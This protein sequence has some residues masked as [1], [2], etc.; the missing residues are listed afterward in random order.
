MDN[1]TLTVKNCHRAKTVRLKEFPQNGNWE[2]GFRS[3][4]Q[5]RG[6]FSTPSN[7]AKQGDAT[8]IVADCELSNYEVI[9]WKYEE[10]FEDLFVLAVR[11]FT[12]TSHTPEVRA[13]QYIR[14]Y[15]S[16]LQSDLAQLPKESHFDYIAKFKMRIEDLFRLHSRCL[17]SM[18]IGLAR[19]PTKRAQS[20]SNSYDK[21]VQ[22]FTKWRES[23]LKRAERAKE[24]AKSPEEKLNDEWKPLKKD[25][26]QTG[27]SIFAI[28]TENYPAHR[29]LF[30]SSIYGKLERI[31]LNGKSELLKMA[32]ELVEKLSAG[33]V[34]KGG[35]PMFT[36]RHKVW[37]LPEVCEASKAKT[38]AREKLDDVEIP[39]EGGKIVKCYADDRLQIYY[40][41]KPPRDIIDRLKSNGF[42]WSPSNGCWQRQLTDNAYYAAARV[43]VPQ[44]ATS[45]E[46]REFV[47]KLRNAK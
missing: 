13:L 7:V 26:I 16:D 8:V 10:N 6:M 47:I 30:V 14:G 21:A 44:G 28:D 32:L 24:E 34:E 11:A 31:A 33:M 40:D 18:I 38:E 43:L 41:E 9:E 45:D 23:Y 2:W 35:K 36:K 27:A 39:F 22:D 37:K 1:V 12:N 4:P 20:A 29:A 15:E 19:F 5:G 42:R 46:H 17:S 3:G 25:I